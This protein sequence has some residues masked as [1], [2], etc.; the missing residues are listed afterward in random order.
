MMPLFQSE[1]PYEDDAALLSACLRGDQL[2]WTKLVERYNRLVFSIALRS[3]L[4][5][6]DAADIVQTVFIIVLRRL[7]SLQQP[8]RFSSWLITTTQR[9]CWRLRKSRQHSSLDSVP[10]QVDPEQD[11]DDRLI[12]WQEAQTLHQALSMLGDQCRTLIEMLFLREERPPYQ[13]I[14]AELGIAVGS[15]GPVRAR[16]LKRL[17]QQLVTL[18]VTAEDGSGVPPSRVS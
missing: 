9:E 10:E 14:S 8:E 5:E 11:N 7:E 3:G 12:A 15:I 2:A 16:C 13:E 1:S 18:G 17:H 6:Q 4:D